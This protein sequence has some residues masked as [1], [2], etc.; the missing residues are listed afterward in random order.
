MNIWIKITT[1]LEVWGEAI[2]RWWDTHLCAISRTAARNV[3]L[4]RDMLRDSLE[5]LEDH[6]SAEIEKLTLETLYLKD[7]LAYEH[8]RNKRLEDELQKV[9]DRDLKDIYPGLRDEIESLQDELVQ[10][11]KNARDY[12]IE[13]ICDAELLKACETCETK[14]NEAVNPSCPLSADEV[15]TETASEDS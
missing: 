6:D 7:E 8:M 4:E 2:K 1:T 10:T 5:E 15:P 9:K 3:V 14:G 13:D 12:L 11:K